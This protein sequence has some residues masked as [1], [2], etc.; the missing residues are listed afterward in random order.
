MTRVMDMAGEP[1]R[2][3]VLGYDGMGMYVEPGLG[4]A[5]RATIGW[6][7]H[8]MRGTPLP[9]VVPPGDTAI[10]PLAPGKR[11]GPGSSR[12]PPIGNPAGTRRPNA[13]GRQ[14]LPKHTSGQ[15]PEPRE[16]LPAELHRATSVRRVLSTMDAPG[17]KAT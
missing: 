11:C 5:M 13:D 6:F 12:E 3:V 15:R 2:L 17:I 7:D 8:H 10:T 4:E 16:S 9:P 1:K 14:P